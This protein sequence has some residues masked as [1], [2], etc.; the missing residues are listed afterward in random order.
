MI[1]STLKK[2]EIWS[3]AVSLLK[4]MLRMKLFLKIMYFNKI[5][6]KTSNKKIRFPLRKKS[7]FNHNACSHTDVEHG[8]ARFYFFEE[9]NLWT[10]ISI[11]LTWTFVK[12]PTHTN[13]SCLVIH[14]KKFSARQIFFDPLLSGYGT[15][16]YHKKGV[17][18]LVEL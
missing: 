13:N 14:F 2:H 9:I 7:H 8:Y 11:L 1:V 5:D 6:H 4:S 3:F 12:I 18:V 10:F 16:W 15:N 17:Q